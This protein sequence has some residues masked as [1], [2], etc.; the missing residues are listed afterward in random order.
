M[1]GKV[2]VTRHVYSMT[3]PE[4]RG[5]WRRQYPRESRLTGIETAEVILG[6]VGR[7]RPNLVIVVDAFAARSVNPGWEPRFSW[8]I[9]G[10]SRIWGREQE[11]RDNSGD[12]W[13]SCMRVLTVVHA[14]TIVADALSIRQAPAS[15]ISPEQ[16]GG[17]PTSFG[18]NPRP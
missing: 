8:A 6:V 18:D 12:P 17:H 15:S 7:V 1:A 2:M 3:P 9:Q 16:Q 5:G 14:M 10:S 13:R 11:V 4:K